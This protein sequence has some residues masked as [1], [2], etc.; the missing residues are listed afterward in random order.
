MP[1]EYSDNIVTTQNL[2]S[3][4]LAIFF[5]KLKKELNFGILP[6]CLNIWKSD[7]NLPEK[8]TYITFSVF[9]SKY[10]CLMNFECCQLKQVHLT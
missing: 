3:H 8:E 9:F 10:S 5:F 1:Y 7:R 4:F 6:N 2:K